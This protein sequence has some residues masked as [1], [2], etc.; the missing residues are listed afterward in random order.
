MGVRKSHKIGAAILAARA[1]S[2][3]GV[4]AAS[5][6]KKQKQTSARTA[7][8]THDAQQTNDAGAKQTNNKQRADSSN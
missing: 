4:G 7:H 2:I 1:K 8:R 3:L 6:A 5:K